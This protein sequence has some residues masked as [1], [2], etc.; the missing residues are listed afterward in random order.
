[1]PDHLRCFI[2]RERGGWKAYCVEVDLS[3]SGTTPDA[4]RAAL[5]RLLDRYCY[6]REDSAAAPQPARRA[7]FGRR[8]RYW[9]ARLLGHESG[10]HMRRCYEYHSPPQIVTGLS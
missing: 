8:S 5:D 7:G 9:A 1:M 4:A 6:E 10:P 2:E 3:A